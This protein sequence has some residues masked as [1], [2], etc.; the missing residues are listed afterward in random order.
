MSQRMPPPGPHDQEELATVY[1]HRLMAR[2]VRYLAPYRARLALAAALLVLISALELAGPLLIKT[3]IDQ[4]I[5]VGDLRGLERLAGLYLLLLLVACSA[6]YG[7]TLALNLAG[8]RAMHDLRLELFRRVERQSLAFFDRRPVGALITRLTNDVEALN[9]FLTA[10]LLAIAALGG[11]G[12]KLATGEAGPGPGTGAAGSGSNP[13]TGAAGSSSMTG[14]AGSSATGGA[15]SG[16]GGTGTAGTGAPMT[17]EK[18]TL[19]M[20]EVHFKK[21][22]KGREIIVL[23]DGR[24]YFEEGDEGAEDEDEG[25]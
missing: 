20:Y 3:A 1:D 25:R 16:G 15:G 12:C 2:L 7:Q 13:M 21:D 18:K 14:G 6:R 22:G 5:A 11:V 23:P 9:E 8:Q 4:H 17:F 19:V 24:R 10:G